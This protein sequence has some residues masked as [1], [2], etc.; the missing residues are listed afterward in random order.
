MLW[1]F[2]TVDGRG[3]GVPA[4]PILT[5]GLAPPCELL[6]SQSLYKLHLDNAEH[7]FGSV[8]LSSSG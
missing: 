4:L 6:L 3:I 2:L 7:R 1:S 5:G 8:V